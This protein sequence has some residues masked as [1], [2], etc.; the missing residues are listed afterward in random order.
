MMA[1]AAGSTGIEGAGTV[2]A[3]ASDGK[4][5]AVGTD[6]VETA[7]IA[8]AGP[9]AGAPAMPRDC[10]VGTLSVEPARRVLGLPLANASGLPATKTAIICGRLMAVEGRTRLAIASRVSPDLTGP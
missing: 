1:G 9:G 8:A 4:T 10:G 5:G 2:G 7:A 6:S 3:M